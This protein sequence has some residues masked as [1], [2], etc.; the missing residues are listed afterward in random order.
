M[1]DFIGDL[2]N[3]I[4]KVMPDASPLW[5]EY[6]AI[7]PLSTILHNARIIEQEKPMSLNLYILMIAISG[8]KKSL[9]MTAFTYPILKET[10]RL[11]DKDL[12]LPSRWSVPGFIKEVGK[13][14]GEKKNRAGE[15][16][17]K[18]IPTHD[19]GVIMRDEFSSMFKGMREDGWQSDGLEFLSEMYDKIYQKRATTSHG[20]NLLT[21]LH[22]NLI[23]C[24]TYRFIGMMD[25]EFFIQGTGNRFMYCHYSMDDYKVERL[26]WQTYFNETWDKQKSGLIQ[27]NADLLKGI[28][29]RDVRKV[30]ID[31]GAE[32]YADYKFECDQEWKRKGIADPKGWTYQPIKRYHEFALK[33]S[34]LYA[35]SD[36]LEVILKMPHDRWDNSVSVEKSHM[37]RAIKTVEEMRKQF[38]E[39]VH[40]KERDMPKARVETQEARAKAIVTTLVSSKYGMLNAGEWM[41]AQII[42]KGDRD[43]N[44]LR[45]VCVSQKYV[46]VLTFKDMTEEQREYFG[47]ESHNIKFYRYKEP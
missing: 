33:L 8:M 6:C 5:C 38:E 11:I 27:K 46:D 31:G 20:L 45:E 17:Q 3:D 35:I 16:T 15:I 13:Q 28:H 37:E 43:F 29:Q 36:R 44:R 19:Q 12:I 41:K 2:K 40:I 34:A 32:L 30:Y 25:P 7:I 42:A 1:S 22:A 14:R 24:S 9:P 21:E 47:T 39:I 18:G 4:L 10:G 23:S 26:D